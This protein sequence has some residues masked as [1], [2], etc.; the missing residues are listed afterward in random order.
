MENKIKS[1]RKNIKFLKAKLK[2]IKAEHYL[3]SD[4]KLLRK[5]MKIKIDLKENKNELFKILMKKNE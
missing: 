4:E 3:F 5:I 1:L 2:N